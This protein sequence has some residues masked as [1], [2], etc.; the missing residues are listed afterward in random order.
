MLGQHL[1]HRGVIKIS[2]AD[3]EEFLQ[4]IITQDV[5]KIS[6]DT[7]VYSC[8][9]TPQ[10]KYLAD[11]FITEMASDWYFDVDHA[12]L[13]DLIKRL[14]IYKLRSRVM[15]ENVSEQFK[16]CALWNGQKPAG[17][18]VDPRTSQIGGR[19]FISPDRATMFEQG[20]YNYW[21]LQNGLPDT[22][23]FIRERSMMLESNMDLLN[24]VSFD[25]G[26]YMG[27]ELTARTHYR[28]LI[29]KRLLPLRFSKDATISFDAE[30]RQEDKVIGHMRSQH[31]DHGLA[32]LQLEHAKD[33]LPVTVEGAEAT[34]FF[35]E[36]FIQ[37]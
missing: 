30:V 20:D 37:P 35:P 21:R 7:L 26:C 1:E 23:D 13:E 9:L 14:T 29:K 25:K 15:I 18:L 10:G 19:A 17:C 24:A 4:G 27:Q 16:I 33:G 11:F 36:W 22:N 5:R 31:G 34:V 2:G 6:P 28:A 3:K 8:F 32:L 12:L